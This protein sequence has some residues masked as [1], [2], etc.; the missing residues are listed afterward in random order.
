M[1]IAST[2]YPETRHALGLK[3][4]GARGLLS[5]A[6]ANSIMV[7]SAKRPANKNITRFFKGVSTERG[8]HFVLRSVCTYVCV[9]VCVR[10][11]SRKCVREPLCPR[12]WIVLGSRTVVTAAPFL[13]FPVLHCYSTSPLFC[14]VQWMG[15]WVSSVLFSYC[16]LFQLF[17]YWSV[18]I[19]VCND[20]NGTSEMVGEGANV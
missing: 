19:I 11:R 15:M 14:S 5:R 4:A 8:G 17:L 2:N 13:H 20:N 18:C 12:E 6:I 16:A 7:L 3:T 1:L 9:C 10:V